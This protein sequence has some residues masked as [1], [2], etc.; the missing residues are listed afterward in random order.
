MKPR[1]TLKMAAKS[2]EAL[3]AQRYA[4]GVS[5]HARSA[6]HSDDPACDPVARQYIPSAEELID[7]AGELCDPIGDAVHSP[8]KGIVHRYPDRAL[9]KVTAVCPVYCRYCFRKT[10]V[11]PQGQA[12]RK[13]DRQAALAYIAANPQIYE[14][15]LTGGDPLMLSAERLG[16]ELDAL[17]AIDHVQVLRIHT[18]MPVADP[19][20]I[21]A[22]YLQIFARH[23]PLYMVVHINHAQEITPQVEATFAALRSSGVILLSQSVLLRGVNDNAQALEVLFRRLVALGVKPYMLHHLDHAPG[24]AHFRVS[25]AEGQ[26]L[27][28]ALRGRLSGLCL[29]EYMLDIPEGHGKVP[30]TPSYCEKLADDRGYEITDYKGHK[31]RYV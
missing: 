25:I 13:G 31:H 16:Q 6:M 20:R 10:M 5:D 21:D 22:A 26:D 29:P 9:Y 19:A 2:D 28:R 12:L 7:T 8:V 17:A 4:A 24:T 15:I 11:G 14:V 18:R 3:L 27:L 30:L 1:K 23:S